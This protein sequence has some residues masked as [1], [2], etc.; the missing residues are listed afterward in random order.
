MISEEK[1]Q[2]SLNLF[3]IYIYIYIV[4][5]PG[6]VSTFFTEYEQNTKQEVIKVQSCCKWPLWPACWITPR[7]RCS[8]IRVLYVQLPL[9]SSAGF[10]C[11]AEFLTS[12]MHMNCSLAPLSMLMSVSVCSRANH[13]L[14]I[15]LI[16][17]EH[18]E[19]QA[20]QLQGL[21]S[22]IHQWLPGLKAVRW[23]F[24]SAK[25]VQVIKKKNSNGSGSCC[26]RS[27]FRL[28]PDCEDIKSK[29]L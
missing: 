1:M 12:L 24:L 25:P 4:Y 10:D 20:P 5:K 21:G 26:T 29:T 8:I 17:V 15:N 6:E 2:W 16:S 19:N 28:P 3:V 11:L 14:L 7:F 9:Q 22:D 13:C 27:N 18:A 23:H